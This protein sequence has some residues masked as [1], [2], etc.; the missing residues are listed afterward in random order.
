MQMSVLA[1][2]MIRTLIGFTDM[3]FVL[4]I[5]VGPCPLIKVRTENYFPYFS[6]KTYVLGTQKNR[7]DETVLLSIKNTCFS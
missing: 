5:V 1:F 3:A 2:Y 4:V 6:T 7:L